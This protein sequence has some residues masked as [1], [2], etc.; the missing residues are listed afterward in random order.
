LRNFGHNLLPGLVKC[1]GGMGGLDTASWWDCCLC[2]HVCASTGAATCVA[3]AGGV[4]GAPGPPGHTGLMD[5]RCDC[6]HRGLATSSPWSMVKSRTMCSGLLF[7]YGSP[8][9]VSVSHHRACS[10]QQAHPGY[11]SF[12][13]MYLGAGLR[14]CRPSVSG[15]PLGFFLV[16]GVSQ[17][18]G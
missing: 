10:Q 3:I 2:S 14:V 13:A 1:A 6:H 11:T 18:V 12:H 15:P 16:R 17:L 8:P 5:E 9:C 7:R 4:F